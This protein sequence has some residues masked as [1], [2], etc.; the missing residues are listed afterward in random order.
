MV[1]ESFSSKKMVQRYLVL[2]WHDVK[3][4]TQPTVAGE[5]KLALYMLYIKLSC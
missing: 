2:I 4:Q 5:K 3:R 1:L